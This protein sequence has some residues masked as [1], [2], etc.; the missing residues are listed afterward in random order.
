MTGPDLTTVTQGDLW[1][2]VLAAPKGVTVPELQAETG[3]AEATIRHVLERWVTQGHLAHAASRK[4]GK[5]R[6]AR[7]YKVSAKTPQ[8]FGSPEY[9]MWQAARHLGTFSAADLAAHSSVEGG[10]VTLEEAHRYCRMLLGAGYLRVMSKAK[11]GKS[12][13]RYKLIKKTGPKAPIRR[14]VTVVID[15][16]TGEVQLPED[17]R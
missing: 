2:A 10:P 16:N 7:V 17:L 12:P 13:A 4:T 9:R 14:R 5:T 11:P 15:P 3:V 6:D 8:P 1:Q